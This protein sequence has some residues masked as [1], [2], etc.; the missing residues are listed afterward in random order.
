MQWRKADGTMRV[1]EGPLLNLGR[2]IPRPM[3]DHGVRRALFDFAYGYASGFPV[4]DVLAFSFRSLWPSRP[5]D[6]IVEPYTE[7]DQS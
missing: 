4:R 6:A 5:M 3:R 7:S 2:G 1:Y